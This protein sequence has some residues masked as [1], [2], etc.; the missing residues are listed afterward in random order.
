MSR[1]LALGREA[2]EEAAGGGAGRQTQFQEP[3]GWGAFGVWFLFSG[4]AASRVGLGSSLGKALPVHP[5]LSP[6]DVAGVTRASCPLGQ[7]A[8]SPFGSGKAF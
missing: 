2:G 4:V 3:K 5:I 7:G 8:W 6:R 1:P